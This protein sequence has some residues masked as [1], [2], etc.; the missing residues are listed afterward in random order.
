MMVSKLFSKR[1]LKR[2]LTERLSE[3]LHL[4]ALSLVVGALGRNRHKVYF[5][6]IQR[7]HNAYAIWSSAERAQKIGRAHV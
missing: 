2:L 4:N 7:Q 5:D 6:L 1:I 3:P